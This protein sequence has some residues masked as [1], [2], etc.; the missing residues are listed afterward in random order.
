M[1]APAGSKAP[2]P[3]ASATAASACATPRAAPGPCRIAPARGANRRPPRGTHAGSRSP[4]GRPA[5]SSW[6]CS[7]KRA[8]LLIVGVGPARGLASPPP[9]TA[10]ATTDRRSSASR[11]RRGST[12][13]ARWT[14]SSASRTT[15]TASRNGGT[16]DIP[17]RRLQIADFAVT[18]DG[19]HRDLAPG[20]DDP[21]RG[22]VRWFGSA[23]HDKVERTSTPTSSATGSRTPSRC[24]PTSAELEWQFIGSRVPVPRA[25]RGRRHHAGRRH[26]SPRLRPRRP[27]WHRRA[28][29][30]HASSFACIDNPAGS[31]VEARIVVPSSLFSVVPSRRARARPHPGRGGPTRG[32]GQR[33]AGGGR[34]KRSQAEVERGRPTGCGDEDSA[35]PRSALRPLR[36]LCSTRPRNRRPASRS[37]SRTPS[38]TSRCS[39]PA[40]RSTRRSTASSTSATP[41]S[42]TSRRRSSPVSAPSLWF[43][44]WRKW[45]KDPIATDRHRRLLAG[46]P[47][48]VPSRHRRRR[49]LGGDRLQGLRQHDHRPGPAGLAHD[50]RGRATATGS[51]ASQQTED[52]LPLRDYESKALWRLFNDGRPTV[53]QDELVDEAKDDRTSS[54][55]VDVGLQ[56]RGESRLRRAAVP[57][58]AGVPALAPPRAAG[59]R[60]A[61]AQPRWRSCCR[62]GSVAPSPRPPRSSSSC[63]ASSLRRRTEKGARKHAEVAGP[64]GASSRD[65]SLV[66][67]VPVGPPRALR[68]LPRLRRRPRRRRP[69]RRW[70]AHAVPG[71]RRPESGLRPLVRVRH[72]SH[73]EL[74]RA[75]TGSRASA[76]SA[77][78]PATSRRPRRARSARRRRR[79]GGGGG[80]SGGGGGGGGGRR[81]RR[82]VAV[83]E[84]WLIPARSR[85]TRRHAAEYRRR[86]SVVRPRAGGPVR[87]RA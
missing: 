23:D 4:I 58:Q 56:G 50:H 11:S 7:V 48:G 36:R 87:R 80:F 28:R 79:R 72:R 51:P 18:E 14:S 29:R 55:N 37:A 38:C 5:P 39:R 44:V 15:S 75:S 54:A 78:S 67:D 41:A 3:A 13:T 12:P 82:L 77:R 57:G 2:S 31:L 70:A 30:Q 76:R 26:R 34:S 25:G 86:R 71:A 66:D 6:A 65:F 35:P 53:T 19:E 33:G 43:L 52:E 8:V 74:R 40:A 17:A 24:S 9:A 16:R 60:R 81:R 69:A 10:Q 62:L 83:A 68:A 21:N 22:E 32:R 42:A 73:G 27:A 84:P 1:R 85:S 20:F 49:R 46:G 45:G 63:S 64:Q 61:A 47:R 59:A